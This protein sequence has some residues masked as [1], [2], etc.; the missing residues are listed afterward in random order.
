ML[1][2][3]FPYISAPLIFSVKRHTG[4]KFDVE[5]YR[6]LNNTQCVK[7]FTKQYHQT[8]KRFPYGIK[9]DN[10][11]GIQRNPASLCQV[12]LHGHILCFYFSILKQR[13]AKSASIYELALGLT[14]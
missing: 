6:I 1:R 12:K 5:E 2:I 9:N 4:V 7:V 3:H 11:C 10:M 13:S 8:G 14:G